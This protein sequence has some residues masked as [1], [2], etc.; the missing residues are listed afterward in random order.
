MKQTKIRKTDMALRIP[1]FTEVLY[2]FT[3]RIG[4]QQDQDELFLCNSRM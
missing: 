3:N 1:Q 2:M 4:L